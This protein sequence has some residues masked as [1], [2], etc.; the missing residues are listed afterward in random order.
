[1]T[2]LARLLDAVFPPPTGLEVEE[3]DPIALQGPLA[4]GQFIR[5]LP[6]I[7]GPDAVLY[8]EGPTDRWL[9]A[10]LRREAGDPDRRIV[11]GL[12]PVADFYHVP[13]AAEVLEELATRLESGPTQRSRV[14]LHVHEGGRILLQW[15][16]AFRGETI[17][18]SRQVPDA[19]VA[20]FI[21][22]TGARPVTSAASG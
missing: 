22:A 9:A 20:A 10:W 13:V 1:M 5:A 8:W 11:V 3:P 12:S 4:P 2:W 14:H 17:L 7:A 21:Q 18:V 6:L 16:R 15:R 19:Q